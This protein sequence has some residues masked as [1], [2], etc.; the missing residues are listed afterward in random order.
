MFG[1]DGY[2]CPGCEP[3]G[4]N[5]FRGIT[6]VCNRAIS[7]LVLLMLVAVVVT[8]VVVWWREARRARA[9]RR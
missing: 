3:D 1:G 7:T 4:W 5:L 2:G 9:A 8:F 6:C